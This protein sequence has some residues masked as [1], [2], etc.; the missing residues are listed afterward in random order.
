MSETAE[1]VR[2]FIGGGALV[3]VSQSM[4]GGRNENGRE[5]W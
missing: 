3:I 1:R 2:V 4:L 5:R